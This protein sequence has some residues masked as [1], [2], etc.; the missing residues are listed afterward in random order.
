MSNISQVL[1]PASDPGAAK[2]FASD[3]VLAFRTREFTHRN[4][5][6]PLVLAGLGALLFAALVAAA[7]IRII[8]AEGFGGETIL[9]I[10]IG[11]FGL[12]M[13]VVLLRRLFDPKSRTAWQ[14][15][16]GDAKKNLTSGW[17]TVQGGAEQAD[18][19]HRLFTT[20]D[21]GRFPKL[22]LG[23]SRSQINVGLHIFGDGAPLYVTIWTHEG[24]DVRA[25]PLVI[26]RSQGADTWAQ[27]II[28]GRHGIGA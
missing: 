3:P 2:A 20:G 16:R 15:V 10:V 5:V 11:A 9:W 4:T 25:W 7:V 27:N 13:V 21:V 23:R 14:E 24:A 18:D 28:V 22:Q 19:L 8:G 26:V 12:L 1:E 6:F 17:Y